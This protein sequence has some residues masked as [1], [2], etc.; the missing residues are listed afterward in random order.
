V[1]ALT[2]YYSRKHR[3]LLYVGTGFVVTAILDGYH[4]LV[5]S[6][7]FHHLLPSPPSS[8]IPWSWNASRTVLAFLMCASWWEWRWEHK[9][10]ARRQHK[11]AMVYVVVTA[12]TLLSFCFFAFVPLPPAYYPDLVFGRPGEFVA[13][14]FFAVALMGYLRKGEW[15]SDAFE[16]WCV[17]SLI[18]GLISQ[19]VVMSRSHALFD[20]M[21]DLAH[22]LKIAGYS[23]VFCGLLIGKFQLFRQVELSSLKLSKSNE[24][25]QQSVLCRKKAESDL[26]EINE[27][28]EQR[29]CELQ[30]SRTAALNTMRDAE[31][32]RH[33]AEELQITA[34]ARESF[35]RA[36]VEASLDCIISIDERGE[37]VEFNPA[38][39][40]TFCYRRDD[41]IGKSMVSLIIPAQYRE[42]HT[43]GFNRYLATREG[44]VLSQRF[45]VTAMR[46]DMT[47]FP[48]ELAIVVTHTPQ[49]II[50]TAYLRDLM[51]VKKAS[52]EHEET[53][54]QLVEASRQAGMAEIATGVL[55]N[56]GNV[57][58]SVNVSANLLTDRLIAGRIDNLQKAVA[59]LEEHSDDPGTFLMRHEKGRRLPGY[60]R[61]LSDS[62]SDDR[63]FMRT[64]VTSL[65]EK[66]N[67]IKE[68][69]Q[70]QQTYARRGGQTEKIVLSELVEIALKVNDASLGRHG[71]EIQREF[72]DVPAIETD[73]HHVLQILVNL[74]SN[75]RN[76]MTEYDG[77]VR[78]LTIR[79]KLGDDGQALIE[80]QDTGSGIA[81]DNLDRIFGHG[82][83]TR[84]DGHGFGLH[85]SANTANEL[86]GS[87]TVFSDGPDRGA[88]FTLHLPLKKEETCPTT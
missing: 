73:K 52:D 28:L 7:F 17:M 23:C 88:V 63:D 75:A 58:N 70:V 39:E 20:A 35:I 77:E 65:N 67:H 6:S 40:N 62:L 4:C 24:L 48:A 8:L 66:V 83:T 45:E 10:G 16:H 26:K 34:R 30:R 87:L 50:L 21:F 31:A 68:V 53:H 85:S 29:A 12:L 81:P 15:R 36:I 59:M 51:E 54:R 76:A 84:R 55:H 71:I 61:K 13:A 25:L 3:T 44:R 47:E 27:S 49:G 1:I 41:V 14:L 43:T 32:A 57:L 18:L 60:L 9:L 72:D 33:K 64:E 42:Q 80:V 82:F 79:I 86:G 56:A 78:R 69:I 46:S 38:A 19:A 37:I 22:L 2:R 11:E 5:T 74:I